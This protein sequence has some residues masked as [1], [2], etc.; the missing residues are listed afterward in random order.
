VKAL[1][2]GTACVCALLGWLGAA[3]VPASEISPV[4][5]YR[6]VVKR[7][8]DE[9]RASHFAWNRLAE[10][11]DTF[12]P[13]LSGS[14][15]L[16]AALRWAAEEMKRD[17]LENVRLEK[18]MVPRWVRGRESLE[19]VEPFPS[20]LVMLGLGNSVGTPQEG[21]TGEV[22]PVRS[23]EELESKAAQA[24]GRIVFFNV[25]FTS[26]GETVRYRGAGPS[27][28]A[29]LGALAAL[30]RAVG[31][32]GLRTPHTGSTRYEDDAPKIPAAAVSAEDANRLQRIHDRG[33]RLVVRL[34]ME[35]Q[36]QGDAESANLIGEIPGREAPEEIV[37]VGGH[38]D[39]WDVGTGAMDDGGGVIATWEALRVIKKL[40]L[41]PRRTLRVV[42]FTN[43]ENGGRGAL[44][45]RDAHRAELPKHVLALESDN[46]AF[47]LRGF[48]F[49]GGAQ[50][51]A[52]IGEI[53]RLLEP[54]SA[55]EVGVG[56]GGADVTPL[57]QAASAMGS[58]LPLMSPLVDGS[59]YFIYHHTPADT[60]E[61]LDPDEVAG[62]AAGI[63][64]MGFV[65]ADV[66][67]RLESAGG[68]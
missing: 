40:G 32:I 9:A 26:Y 22:L 60:V 39:S 23:F 50:A 7:I 1:H 57:A 66:P 55:T 4:E 13:R 5:G 46:G 51:R 42:A 59:R 30:I 37:L 15:A 19:I 2:V 24:R 58:S 21:I 62:C 25:D 44:A 38:I 35:A 48:G 20:P 10:M 29:R 65:V 47:K 8:L 52:V 41:R 17:G 14:P 3:A 16:E 54:L 63:A 27:R 56:G 6:D 67:F 12:G 49:T 36:M 34:K 68:R 31:P 45:Y 28:A 18:A 61:R 43:E 64:A 33:R 53:A 11:T